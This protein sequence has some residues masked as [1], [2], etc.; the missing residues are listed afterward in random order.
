M[1]QEVIQEKREIEFITIPNN[2][3]LCP[4]CK[5]H[6]NTNC[7]IFNRVLKE[8]VCHQ[9]NKSVGTNPFYNPSYGKRREFVGIRNFSIQE[10]EMLIQKYINKGLNYQ[11][12]K[13]KVEYDLRIISNQRTTK[14]SPE[15][16]NQ[17]LDIKRIDRT[18]TEQL[19]KGLGIK[20]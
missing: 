15:P 2:K 3:L 1:E 4:R 18:E 14:I 9:C 16:I 5:R 7:F 19:I 12:A 10:R 20:Q 8:Q 17:N 6:L 13:N 11:T